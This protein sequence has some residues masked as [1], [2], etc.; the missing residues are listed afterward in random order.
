MG[1]EYKHFIIPS[2]PSFVPEKNIIKKI[3][4]VLIKWNL[5]TAVPKIYNL[6]NGINTEILEPL[7]NIEFGQ[8]I[9]IEYPGIDG[10]IVRNI[11]GVSC[12]GDEVS[13]E[14]RYIHNFNFIVG[15]DFRIHPDSQELNMTVTTPPT[16]GVNFLE[17]Y[18]EYDEFLHYGLHSQC[19]KSTLDTNPPQV[20][21]WAADEKRLIGGQN[22][23]G[24]WRTAFIIDFGKDL[25]YLS[26]NEIYLTENKD[27]MKDLEDAFGISL[28][29]IGEVY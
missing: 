20:E 22:F 8:G 6:T 23:L 19:Y 15:L 2:N 14:N 1:V 12:Y 21:I 11:F 16:D 26:N 7:E 17:P 18:C 25:P 3:D 27:F 28:I 24:Y 10:N 13:D 5:K 29:E 4:E 9:C